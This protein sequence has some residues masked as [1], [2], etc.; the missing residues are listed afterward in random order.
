MH[1]YARALYGAQSPHQH[2][3]SLITARENAKGP[4]DFPEGLSS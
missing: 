4:P 2:E 3:N 1:D